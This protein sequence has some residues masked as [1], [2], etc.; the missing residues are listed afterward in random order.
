MG[1][2]LGIVAEYNPFHSGHLYQMNQAIAANNCQ[3]TIVAMSGNFVQRGEPAIMDKWIRSR[4][5]VEAGADLVVEIPC[6]HVL[7]SAEGFARAAIGLLAACGADVV[8]FGSERGNL[9]E[10][11]SVARWLDEPSSQQ[12]IRRHVKTGI[13]Y[14]SAIETALRNDSDYGNLADLLAGPNNILALEYLRAAAQLATPLEFHTVLRVGPGHRSTVT[15]KYASASTLRRLLTLGENKKALDYIPVP[16]AELAAG[17]LSNH[18]HVTLASLEQAIKYALLSTSRQQLRKLPAISEGLENRL[19]QQTEAQQEVEKLLQ[20]TTT[21][22][23][24]RT[25]LQRILC[26]LLLGFENFHRHQ[27]LVPYIRVLAMSRQGKSMLPLLAKS[28]SAPLIVGWRDTKKLSPANRD[29]IRLD[30]HAGAVHNLGCQT[31]VAS[32]WQQMPY[33]SARQDR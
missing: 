28:G 33:V 31:P 16:A 3:G 9:A 22:R 14:A 26:Q 23:Y 24:P 29:L 12:A 20:R 15:G 27:P 17:W 5:A 11:Q 6:W 32:D 7:Q 10:L 25:R 4:I 1:K 2:W 30:Q 18:G 19:L 13:S 21:R 8:S